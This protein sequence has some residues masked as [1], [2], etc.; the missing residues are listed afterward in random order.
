MSILTLQGAGMYI[1]G[2]T[3]A[4]S[5]CQIYSNTASVVRAQSIWTQ[6]HERLATTLDGS[7]WTQKRKH[8]L[9]MSILML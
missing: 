8:L 4:V 7:F 6:K 5:G 3:V 2:S 9:P 1:V